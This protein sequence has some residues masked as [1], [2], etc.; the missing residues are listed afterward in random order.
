TIV[1]AR[2]LGVDHRVGTLEVGKDCDL[3]LTDGDLLHYQTFVQYAVVAGKQVYDKSA[4]LYFAHIRP[5]P[6]AELAPETRVDPGTE[7]SEEPAAPSEPEKPD[8]SQEPP[9]GGEPP[10]GGG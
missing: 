10:A 6:A 2:L 7:P 1:P 9:K 8:E 3:I 4:E 5:R